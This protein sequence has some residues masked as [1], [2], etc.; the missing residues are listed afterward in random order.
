MRIDGKGL[1]DRT[2]PVRFRFDGKDYAG[3]RSSIT[4]RGGF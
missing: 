1:I 4:A 3:G 2:K